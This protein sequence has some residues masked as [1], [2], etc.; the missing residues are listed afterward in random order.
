LHVAQ[1]REILADC[2][3]NQ[4]EHCRLDGGVGDKRCPP[5]HAAR[6]SKRPGRSPGRCHGRR[7]PGCD[8]FG[9][10]VRGAKNRRKQMQAHIE[11]T[12]SDL[13]GRIASLNEL[14]AAL[15][16]LPDTSISPPPRER[17]TKTG[18][19]APPAGS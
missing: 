5:A 14:I 7:G 11:Q 18:L 4:N 6:L 8:E 10:T 19:Y 2:V 12:I 1:R 15:E 9:K 17:K 16:S 3:R 13:R